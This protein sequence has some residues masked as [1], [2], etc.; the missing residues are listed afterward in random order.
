[1]QFL[2]RW[3]VEGSNYARGEFE[4][5]FFRRNAMKWI[6][7]HLSWYDVLSIQDRAT[8]KKEYIQDRLYGRTGK[9]KA[10]IILSTYGGP[11]I[12]EYN[13]EEGG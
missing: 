5:F 1:M 4:Y 7:R 8:G 11:T 2:K 9:P 13:D 10:T 12:I 6:D 3:K